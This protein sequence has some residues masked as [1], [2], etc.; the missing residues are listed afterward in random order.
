[1]LDMLNMCVSQGL[2]VVQSMKRIAHDLH[3]PYPDLATELGIVSQHA[4]IGTLRQAMDNFDERIDSNQVHSFTA[5]ITQ[6]D[7]MGTSVS[8]A[9]TEYSDAMRTSL[10]QRAEEFGNKAAFKLLF[11]TVLCLMPAV[12]IFL[13]GPAFI[14]LSEFFQTGGGYEMLRSGTTAVD[15]IPTYVPTGTQP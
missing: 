2:T 8:S 11:P 14:S 10:S 12:Y 5:L 15:A 13:L 1:M 7:R 3:Q 6:T 4:E 9:L